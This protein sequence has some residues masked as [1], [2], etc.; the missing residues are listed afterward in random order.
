MNFWSDAAAGRNRL[1]S[2]SP[3]LGI[4]LEVLNIMIQERDILHWT[5]INSLKWV[6]PIRGKASKDWPTW[7]CYQ[8]LAQEM[9]GTSSETEVSGQCTGNS[10]YPKVTGTWGSSFP[11]LAGISVLS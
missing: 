1:D 2:S 7:R 9:R 10:K 6:I 8:V 4:L 3:L 11:Y 5:C